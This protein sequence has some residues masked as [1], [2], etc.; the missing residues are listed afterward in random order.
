MRSN[1]RKGGSLGA[2]TAFTLGAA[3][4]SIVSLLCAPTAGRIVRKRIALRANSLKRIASRRLAETRRELV[5]QATQAREVASDWIMER[6]PHQN[7]NGRHATRSRRVLRH[8][9]ARR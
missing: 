7:G 2:A 1:R 8:A 6:V 4:G 5:S 9:S 3:I